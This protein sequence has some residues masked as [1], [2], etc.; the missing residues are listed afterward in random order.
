MRRALSLILVV[1]AT[2]AVAGCASTPR[3][4]Q[5]RTMPESGA[6][7]EAERFL[8]SRL[9]EIHTV[10]AGI[11]LRWLSSELEGPLSCRTSLVFEAPSHLRLRGTSKAF[12]TIFDLI[13]GPEKITI[14][15]PR[16]KVLIV[17]D[18]NDPEWSRFALDPDLVTIALLAH[19][20]PFG[21]GALEIRDEGADFVWE[22]EGARMV[23]DG[24][25]GRPVRY[26]R[27]EPRAEVT[28]ERWDLDEGVPWPRRV[29]LEWPEENNSLEIDF[30]RVQ[31][32]RPVRADYFD[33]TPKDD[34]EILT[35]GQG[36]ERWVEMF[37]REAESAAQE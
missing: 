32:K 5:P 33:E 1:W 13:A 10:H 3:T 28:W 21:H 7:Q 29:R 25:S 20:D 16:E 18:R 26:V 4:E 15:V 35:P 14:D 11:E 31:L 12:F 2:I 19:P 6:R 37:E 24:G 30:W 34:R 8:E 23:I 17:G 22:G 36:I 9:D 27:Q